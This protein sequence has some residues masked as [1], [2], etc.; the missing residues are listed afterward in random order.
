MLQGPGTA[1]Y[2]G[3]RYNGRYAR[4]NG[5]EAESARRLCPAEGMALGQ[6]ERWPVLAHQSPDIGRDAREG[7]AD[8]QAPISALLARDAQR[9]EGHHPAR[10]I[11]RAGTKRCRI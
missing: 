5:S 8:R 6:G 4:R 3:L 1:T 11:A 7:A 9:S 10:G 2:P